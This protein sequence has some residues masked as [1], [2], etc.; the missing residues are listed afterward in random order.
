ME[1]QLETRRCFVAGNKMTVVDFLFGKIV[2]DARSMDL[3]GN[4]PY[5]SEWLDR[6]Q[7]RESWDVAYSDENTF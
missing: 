1:Q 2:N 3:L 5:L 7:S 6:M 4:F